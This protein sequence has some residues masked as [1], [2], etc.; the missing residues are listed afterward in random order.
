VFEALENLGLEDD[1]LI[2]FTSDHGE[3]FLEH[4][5]MFHGQS[6][7]GELN[8]VPFIVR[9]PGWVQPGTVVRETV[10]TVDIMPTILELCGL[11]FPEQIQGRS[12]A[13]ALRGARLAADSAGRP[14]FSQRVPTKRAAGPPP[15]EGRSYA[16]VLD[17]WKLIENSMEDEEGEEITYELYEHE[18][19][20]LDTTD[21]AA[22]RPDLVEK[23]SARLAE[24]LARAETEKLTPDS[25]IEEKLSGEELER[26]RALGYLQ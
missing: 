23:L 10:E 18:K 14:A 6:V 4:G 15:W 17:G 19:D 2:V 25:E 5:R 20:P 13:P 9:G 3:E 1:T 8:Q 26:L 12:L 21:L 24:L 22:D 7:Y 11:P 16:I